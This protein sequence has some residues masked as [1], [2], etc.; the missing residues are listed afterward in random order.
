[1]CDQTLHESSMEMILV[2][3]GYIVE[4]ILSTNAKTLLE[5]NTSSERFNNLSLS[6]DDLE[7]NWYTILYVNRQHGWSVQG[8]KSD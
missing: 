7:V 6:Y 4:D 3:K 2:L 1:M 8:Q 5:N